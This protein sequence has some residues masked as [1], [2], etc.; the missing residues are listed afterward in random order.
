M[1]NKYQK[2]DVLVKLEQYDMALNE[3]EKLRSLMPRE[4]PIPMLIGKIYKK[5]NNIEKAHYYF[6]LALDLESKDS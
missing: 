5:K 1:L 4:A 3:L 6:T 2:A